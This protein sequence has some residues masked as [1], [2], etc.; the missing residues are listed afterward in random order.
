MVVA[1]DGIAKR[2]VG[3]VFFEAF[4]EI[5]KIDSGSKTVHRTASAKKNWVKNGFSETL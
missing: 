5:A 4:M 3:T 1:V 2:E